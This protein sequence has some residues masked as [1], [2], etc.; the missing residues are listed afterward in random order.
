MDGYRLRPRPPGPVPARARPR[1]RLKIVSFP[2]PVV[3]PVQIFSNP[4]LV[5][6]PKKIGS[7]NLVTEIQKTPQHHFNT[8]IDLTNPSKGYRLKTVGITQRLRGKPHEQNADT[9]ER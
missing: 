3:L 2:R 4:N 7:G 6:R 8:Q 1:R 5:P 9:E